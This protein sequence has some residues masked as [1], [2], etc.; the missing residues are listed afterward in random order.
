MQIK[1]FT[2]PLQP[3]DEQTEEMNH[4]LRANKV[5]DVKKELA[6]MDGNHVWTFCVTYIAGAKPQNQQ[7]NGAQNLR[8]PKVDYKDVLEPDVFARFSALRKLRKAIADEEAIPAYAVFTDAELAEV[9]KLHPITEKALRSVSGIGAKKVEKYGAF[10]CD[11]DLKFG[12]EASRES[13]G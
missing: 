1:V 9:A 5:V 11:F 6:L 4:F 3:L 8:Q 10:F 13:D 12:D 2:L 7:P